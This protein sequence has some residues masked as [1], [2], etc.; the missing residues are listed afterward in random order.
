M[1]SLIVLLALFLASPALSDARIEVGPNG[2]N[3][4]AENKVH[5]PHDSEET[6]NEFYATGLA[7]TSLQQETENGTLSSATGTHRVRLPEDMI[8]DVLRGGR[9]KQVVVSSE[10]TGEA[11]T[12]EANGTTYTSDTWI[13]TIRRYRMHV[14]MTTTCLNGVAQ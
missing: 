2:Y 4:K 3:D 9:H 6:D 10:T 12:I 13:T 11:C 7:I 8:P 1:K 14:T 5:F